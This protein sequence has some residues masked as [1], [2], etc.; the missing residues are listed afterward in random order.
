MS[1]T[2][3]LVTGAAG[4]SGRFL[5][6][7]LR[8][9]APELAILAVDLKFPSQ[10]R[11][12]GVKYQTLDVTKSQVMKSFIA[13]HRPAYIYHLA[14]V[15][16]CDRP[17][18]YYEVNIAGTINLLEAVLSV[19]KSYQPAILNVGSAAEYGLISPDD[20]PIREDCDKHP[21]SFYGNSKLA[22]DLISYQY[23]LRHNL[24]TVRGR[25]FNIIGPGQPEAFVCGSIARQFAMA[26]KCKGKAVIRVGNLD[27]ERDF[28]DIRD[29]VSAY[30]ALAHSGAWGEAFN[31][32]T[33]RAASV[34]SVIE[35]LK[36]EFNPPK[37]KVMSQ[38]RLRRKTDIPRHFADI[39]KI[40]N[41]I[42]W[43]PKYSLAQSLR[44]M[45][46]TSLRAL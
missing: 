26:L 15:I 30:H 1:Q 37:I 9:V 11:I 23:H 12:Q 34:R 4:F 14:G 43:N 22:E 38:P 44:D 21:I 36:E 5:L 16:F 32:A 3:T 24:R 42:G 29:V 17:M 25:P 7:H 6:Q 28:V 8:Q 10:G 19:G 33:G 39:Q 13:R 45:V 27:S 18:L 31:I 20:L 35:I 2:K 41:R 46:E 40:Q